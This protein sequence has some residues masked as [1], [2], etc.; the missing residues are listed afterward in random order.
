MLSAELAI[1]MNITFSMQLMMHWPKMLQFC[2]LTKMKLSHWAMCQDILN[3]E[4]ITYCC[5]YRTLYLI[6]LSKSA[7][8]SLLYL[9][10]DCKWPLPSVYNKK[11]K[12]CFKVLWL[13]VNF[14]LPSTFLLFSLFQ[15]IH[16]RILGSTALCKHPF[17]NANM[18]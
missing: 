2:H 5:I 16:R 13:Y 9:C 6:Y 14:P 8:C 10:F 3:T 18:P 11:K 15:S 17:L 4:Q 1:S 12:M 7:L